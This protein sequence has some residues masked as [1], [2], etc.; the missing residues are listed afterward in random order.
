M[1]EDVISQFNGTEPDYKE[2][3]NI[4]DE[5]AVELIQRLG[6][7]IDEKELLDDGEISLI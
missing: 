6:L 7:D 5:E 1:Q 3:I 2:D 4:Y